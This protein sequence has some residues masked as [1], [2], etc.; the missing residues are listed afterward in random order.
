MFAHLL[1]VVPCLPW[2]FLLPGVDC[3]APHRVQ[4]TRDGSLLDTLAENR[5][6]VRK[7][8]G[9]KLSTVEIHAAVD[10]A[11]RDDD[12]QLVLTQAVE[13]WYQ[14]TVGWSASAVS[15]S[16]MVLMSSFL[17]GPDKSPSHMETKKSPILELLSVKVPGGNTLVFLM[18]WLLIGVTAVGFAPAYILRFFGQPWYF[19]AVRRIGANTRPVVS[20]FHA[21]IGVAWMLVLLHQTVT[22]YLRTFRRGHADATSLQSSHRVVGYIGVCAVALCSVTG[23]Y[24]LFYGS[25]VSRLVDSQAVFLCGVYAASNTFFGIA[26]VRRGNIQAHKQCMVWAIIWTCWP[27]IMRAGN[28]FWSSGAQCPTQCLNQ[29]P[30][31]VPHYCDAVAFVWT[32]CGVGYYIPTLAWRICW[33]SGNV[34]WILWR[35]RNWEIAAGNNIGFLLAAITGNMLRHASGLHIKGEH[36]LK[37]VA[38]H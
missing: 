19:D 30:P 32:E 4:I 23:V 1:T 21:V 3:Y 12:P 20:S 13:G 29:L 11:H 36:W 10:V 26:H 8:Q 27:G 25:L 15:V 33:V 16:M 31:L 38:C 5:S 24:I 37:C 28:Y 9:L 7:Q 17:R 18:L 34:I 35:C 22:A 2:L 14:Q 6:L